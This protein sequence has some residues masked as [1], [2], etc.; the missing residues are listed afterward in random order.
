MTNQELFNKAQMEYI[1]LGEY[2]KKLCNTTNNK[3]KEKNV[4]SSLD[5]MLQLMLM[6][7]A[8]SN[9]SVPDSEL[10]FIKLL[11][12]ESDVVKM[13]NK[14]FDKNI[15]WADLSEENMDPSVLKEFIDKTYLIYKKDLDLFIS[16]LAASDSKT[17]ENDLAYIEERIRNI[18]V[19]FTS[20]NNE[21]DLRFIDFIMEEVFLK[22]YK[23]LKNIFKSIDIK[24]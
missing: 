7:L 17:E 11:T 22:K 8:V 2:I 16:F 24:L 1:D 3:E 12:V 15:S 13:Y 6:Y 20:L 14:A 10:K 9:L 19:I 5:I 23:S 18:L 4:L 21:T